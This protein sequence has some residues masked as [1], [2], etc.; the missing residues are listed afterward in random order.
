MKGGLF[1]CF[2]PKANPCDDSNL[3][4]QMVWSLQLNLPSHLSDFL[5]I[6]VKGNISID[7]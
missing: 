4:L 3:L 6:E 5:L 1:C 2:C 7:I